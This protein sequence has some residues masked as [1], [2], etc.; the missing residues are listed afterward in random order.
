MFLS[1]CGTIL[2]RRSRQRLA[3]PL[4]ERMNQISDQEWRETEDGS[5]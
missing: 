3:P 4:C 1:Q 5:T 2:A